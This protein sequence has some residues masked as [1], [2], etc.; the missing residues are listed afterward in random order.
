MA[1]KSSHD[2]GR[3][4][5]SIIYIVLGA[6]ALIA[7]VQAIASLDVVWAV[8][9]CAGGVVMF[10]A[11]LLGLLNA[12]PGLC[13][14]LGLI[15]FVLAAISFVKAVLAGAFTSLTTWLYLAE[16]ILAWYFVIWIKGNK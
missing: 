7:A 13:R 6:G 14:I 1:K 4:I 9:G 16:A 5:I 3:I 8:I 10:F 12:K 2:L 11:G 15:V